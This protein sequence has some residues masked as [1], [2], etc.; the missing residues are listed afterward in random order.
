[1][2]EAEQ[3]DLVYLSSRWTQTLS[4]HE[5]AGRLQGLQATR[6]DRRDFARRIHVW[7]TFISGSIV[8]RSLAPDASLRQ[9]NGS[10]L[11]QLGWILGALRQ[12]RRFVFVDTLCLL[13]TSGNSGGYGV[14]KVFGNNFQRVTREAL[15]ADAELRAMAEEI[16]H[17]AS[18]AFLPDLV[19]GLKQ[20]AT[21]DFDPKEGI[22]ANLE[23]QLGRSWPYRI[24]I[25]P[26]GY[27]TPSQGRWLLRLAHVAAGLIKY[28]DV[29]RMHLSRQA[30][31]L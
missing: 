25:R 20:G 13:A 16:I 5:E 23:P 2:L 10:Q 19:W 22:A 15:S 17:R 6:M 1:M 31:P 8:R 14:L 4:S 7:T 11:V 27:A 28:M 30:R 26:L 3:P 12:G 9:F 21:G 18:I 24:L 29:A